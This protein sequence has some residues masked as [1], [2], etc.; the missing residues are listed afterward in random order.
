MSLPLYSSKALHLI[1]PPSSLEFD[2]DLGTYLKTLYPRAF[3]SLSL[4]LARPPAPFTI[5]ANTFNIKPASL[6]KKLSQ[7]GITLK[8]I[9]NVSDAF[10]VLYPQTPFS[11]DAPP[12][13]RIVTDK[14]AAEAALQGSNIYGAGIIQVPRLRKGE[15]VAVIS[16]KG[17]YVANGIVVASSKL[18]APRRKGIAVKTLQS[19]YRLPALGDTIAYRQGLF[20]SQ[21]LPAI[22]TSHLL[23]NMF[24]QNT[25]RRL[26]SWIL[27]L[28][29]APGGKT[30]HLM[31]LT[32]GKSVII[33]VD[34]SRTRLKKLFLHVKRLR[35]PFSRT[36]V[37]VEDITR[38]PDMYPHWVN[39]CPAI[40]LDPPCT[41]L[42]VRPKLWETKNYHDTCSM[43][44][45]QEKLLRSALRLL[46]PKGVLLYSTCTLSR[47]EN[48]LL[49]EHVLPAADVSVPSTIK[50]KSL[51][52]LLDI[53]PTLEGKHSFQI[54]FEPHIHGTTG[55]FLSR[56]VKE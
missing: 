50:S 21:S 2:K 35:L 28:C 30:T 38:L 40:I 4:A 52:S 49:L 27:D 3:S 13:K 1:S 54:R 33:A 25:E 6:T 19:Y 16:S 9:P 15:H 12:E 31:Q 39:K 53:L 8:P 22:L 46:V 20:Y 44:L 42:G 32:R 17:H 29:A 43:A 51:L 14:H 45:Y 34:R 18:L 36:R 10:E 23:L 48:E 7:E 55:Y 5:R 41:A 47:L 26:P 24:S 37:I 56:I 11:L